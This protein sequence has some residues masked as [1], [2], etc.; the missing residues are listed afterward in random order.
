MITTTTT[1][2]RRRK[3]RSTA[4]AIHN[5]IYTYRGHRGSPVQ[6]QNIDVAASD[7]Q[8]KFVLTRKR[9]R[10]FDETKNAYFSKA[11]IIIV[12][13]L[14]FISFLKIPCEH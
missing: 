6:R 3:P 7:R 13:R 10:H 5:I 9:D 1:T 4:A 14:F 2:C 12:E 11:M 8:G